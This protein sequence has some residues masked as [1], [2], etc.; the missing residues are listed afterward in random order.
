MAQGLFLLGDMPARSRC[1]ARRARARAAKHACCS[2]AAAGCVCLDG[3]RA[4]RKCAHACACVRPAARRR[5]PFRFS[6][7]VRPPQ[8]SDGRARPSCPSPS[9]QA[10]KVRRPALGPPRGERTSSA[11]GSLPSGARAR[12]A[13]RGKRRVLVYSIVATCAHAPARPAALVPVCLPECRGSCLMWCGA[14]GCCRSPPP[15]ACLSRPC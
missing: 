10:G 14:M 5:R 11:G 12:P 1:C 6:Q 3:G 2:P 7:R 13:G 4:A 15:W 9:P 8:K